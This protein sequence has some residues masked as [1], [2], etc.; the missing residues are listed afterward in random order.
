ML[1][2][3]MPLRIASIFTIIASL[4]LI[5]T[6]PAL[7]AGGGGSYAK[8][9]WSF[10]GIFG[11]YDKLTLQRGF[12]IH[13]EVCAACH[14]LKYVSYRHLEALGYNE[15][16]IKALASE[17]EVTD[18][19]NDEGEMYTRPALPADRFNSP[20][21]NDAAA[22]YANGGALPVDLSLIAKA[23][24]NGPD[25]L[26]ALLT[27]YHDDAPAGVD[28]PDGLYYND[29]YSGNL[30]AM[31]QP[32]YEDQVSY[33]DGHDATVAQMSYD[34]VNFLMWAAEPH[35][36]TRKSLGIKVI[37]FLLFFVFVLYAHKRRL[38]KKLH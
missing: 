14:S 5:A 26:Y 6:N 34:V 18:G 30:I 28:V 33:Q 31:P 37:L 17:Y 9:D 19:P 21:A 20:F 8:Q 32:L 29:A 1:K 7:A 4:M 13:K 27:S 10:T 36:E 2:H 16:Q 12:Q 25:Y 3:N 35:L 23:R 15:A 24:A 11:K 22:R 38:W